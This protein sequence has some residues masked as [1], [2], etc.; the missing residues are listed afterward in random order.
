MIILKMRVSIFSSRTILFAILCFFS[1]CA[2]SSSTPEITPPAGAEEQL[3]SP[4]QISLNDPPIL[5]LQTGQRP[6]S[7]KPDC[8]DPTCLGPRWI[9]ATQYQCEATTS[10]HLDGRAVLLTSCPCCPLP[11]HTQCNNYDCRAPEGSRQCI[12]EELEGCACDTIEDRRRRFETDARNEDY[13]TYGDE[14]FE[15]II[16]VNDDGMGP[17]LAVKANQ[18]T[19]NTSHLQEE[20]TQISDTLAL[21]MVSVNLQLLRVDR[22]GP[23]NIPVSS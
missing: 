16:E 13:I 14:D 10:F 3:H 4:S 17:W 9:C 11:I 1:T 5:L 22:H 19:G 21:P 7:P 8:S 20:A 12:S 23:N 2:Q 18:T 6:T 15:D